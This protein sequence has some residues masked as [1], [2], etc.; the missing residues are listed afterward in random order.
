MKIV[1]VRAY[2]VSEPVRHQFVWR[3]GLPGS[4]ETPLVFAVWARYGQQWRFL[5]VPAG[6]PSLTLNPDPSAGPTTHVVIAA[7]DRCGNE[8]EHVNVAIK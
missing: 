7:V 6:T 8:S 5:T 2:S 1:D 3:K 4:G